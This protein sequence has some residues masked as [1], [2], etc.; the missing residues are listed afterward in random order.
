MV[1]KIKPTVVVGPDKRFIFSEDEGIERSPVFAFDLN[2]HPIPVAGFFDC[3]DLCGNRSH[4]E[5]SRSTPKDRKPRVYRTC[6][7]LPRNEFVGLYG[8]FL[9]NG[10]VIEVL[11]QNGVE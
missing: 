10:V 8:I 7:F 11:F 4:W 1:N 6:T 2:D 5:A 3:K 9:K